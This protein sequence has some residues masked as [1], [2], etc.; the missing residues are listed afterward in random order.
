MHFVVDATTR[1]STLFPMATKA[2]GSAHALCN[3]KPHTFTLIYG[4]SVSK[5]VRLVTLTY[6]DKD[7]PVMVGTELDV[8]ALTS[9]AVIKQI[10]DLGQKIEDHGNP[11]FSDPISSENILWTLPS[12]MGT[13]KAVFIY[14]GVEPTAPVVPTQD[15]D[16][17]TDQ[18]IT[19]AAP[20]EK[21]FA[22]A[23]V[24]DDPTSSMSAG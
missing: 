22:L 9:D 3:L 20:V 19:P 6:G 21:M 23:V 1:L 24:E 11:T 8:A 10:T 7:V 17:V 16:T 15:Q 13:A 4:D 12:K 2:I 18:D 14:K 5:S